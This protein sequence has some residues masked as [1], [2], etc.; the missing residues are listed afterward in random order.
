[1]T[2]EQPLSSFDEKALEAELD[3]VRQE[4]QDQLIH[5]RAMLD[6]SRRFFNASASEPRSFRRVPEEH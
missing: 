6:Q 3:R 5:A 1:M 4:L 2:P